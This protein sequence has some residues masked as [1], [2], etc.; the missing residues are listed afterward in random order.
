MLDHNFLVRHPVLRSL[1][2]EVG[3]ILAKAEV[4]SFSLKLGHLV[5]LKFL[6]IELISK[7][8]KTIVT[9]ISLVGVHNF[10]VS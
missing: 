1:L 8:K 5:T 3:S 2:G 9:G 7:C 6:Y 4:V 10:S